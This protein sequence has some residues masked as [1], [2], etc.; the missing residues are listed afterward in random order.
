MNTSVFTVFAVVALSVAPLASAECIQDQYGNQYNITLDTT[1]KA[2]SGF[3]IMNQRGGER[4]TLSGSYVGSG[5]FR[6]QQITM[7]D[8][9]DSNRLYMLKGRYPNF[10]W[11]YDGVFDPVQNA[12]FTACD[13]PLS[14]PA[15][16]KGGRA[17]VQ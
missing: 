5:S 1:N 9:L 7:A 14:A 17:G 3:A 11:Y 2:I 10:G 6:I 15:G 8:S 13:A 4:W 16:G 12:A